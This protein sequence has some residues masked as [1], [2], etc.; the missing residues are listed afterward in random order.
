MTYTDEWHDQ[1]A[2]TWRASFH[3]PFIKGLQ[4]G[5]L[6]HAIFRNYLIQDHLY[7]EGFTG[8]HYE[9][10]AALPQ[11]QGAILRQLVKESGEDPARDKL[12][13]ALKITATDFATTPVAPTNY[14]YLAHMTYQLHAVNVFAG[15]ASLLPCY[16][17]YA[18]IGARFSQLTSPDPLYQDFFNSY[19][20]ADF[21][22]A[23]N[24]FRQLTDQ[25][26]ETVGP[27]VRQTMATAFFRSTVYEA[28]F[29]EMA[30][31]EEQWPK[32]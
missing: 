7:L 20:S 27:A 28:H 30:N 19:A 6:P 9:L 13:V 29:W 22:A 16:W 26:A 3:H 11:N 8:L 21:T 25:L 15:V 10:A 17:L 24:Q 1:V 31:T 14:A 5:T 32:N 23:A 2:T 4:M 18:E 12:H